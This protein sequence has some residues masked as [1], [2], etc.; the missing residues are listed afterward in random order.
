MLRVADIAV[1]ARLAAD[2]GAICVVDNTFLSPV[3]QR[4]LELGAGLVVHSTTKFLNGHSDV[5]GGAVVA[6]DQTLFEEVASWTNTL[7][8]AGAPFDAYLTLR[9]IRTLHARNQVHEENALRAA[10]ALSNSDVVKHVYHPSLP[11][12]PGHDIARRQQF[13][14]GSLISFELLGGRPAVDA[15]VDGMEHFT[16]A[17]SLGGVESLVAHPATMTHASMEASAQAVAGIGD[18]LLRFS[19]GIEAAADLETDI[20]QALR[21]AEE[22]ACQSV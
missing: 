8:V 20:A 17:E 6:T 13:G 18:S 2:L 14:W 19:V 5:V 22:A 16:L 3:N 12:H 4:P 9:G 11:G 7:G 21:R 15:F 10:A 1:W